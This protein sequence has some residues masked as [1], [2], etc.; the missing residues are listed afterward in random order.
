MTKGLVNVGASPREQLQ[1][2]FRWM[3]FEPALESA[4]RDDQFHDS[5]SYLRVSLTILIALVVAI[6]EIDNVVIPKIGAAVPNG[7][8]LGVMITVLAIALAL[9]FLRSAPRWYPPVT[10]LLM[11]VALMG[12]VWTGLMAWSLGEPRAFVRLVIVTIALYFVLGLRFR[13]ALAANLVAIACYAGAAIA[14]SMPADVLGQ[15]LAMLVMSSVICAI[16]AYNLE[17]ARRTAWLKGQL[18]AELALRDGLTGIHNRRRLDEHLEQVLQQCQRDRKPLALL[19]ADIDYFK[20]YNDHYGHRAGDDALKAVAEVHGLFAR[21]PLDMA[22]RFGGEEFAL[23]LFDTDREQAVRIG[24]AIMDGVLGL[25]IAHAHSAAA[26]SL[27]ISIGMVC[28]VPTAEDSCASLLQRA[29]QALYAAKHGGRNQTH[30]L[31]VAGR[32]AAGFAPA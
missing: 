13:L 20:A 1:R 3:Q 8:R 25:R 29:D 17:H 27:T 30:V 14:I 16:G 7:A 11:M 6:V 19:F 12:V 32:G 10:T 21:R 5:V 24:E 22:A 28:G 15:F 9:T 31:D 4:Y 2:G 26:S 18:L 23:V